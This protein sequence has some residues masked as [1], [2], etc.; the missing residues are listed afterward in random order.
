MKRANMKVDHEGR[1]AVSIHSLRAGGPLT[2]MLEGDSLKKVMFGAYWKN[3]KT[4]WKYIKLTCWK[5]RG[6]L[7]MIRLQSHRRNMQ[8]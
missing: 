3:P 2:K 1:L 4:A 6:P 7:S 5:S 8:G